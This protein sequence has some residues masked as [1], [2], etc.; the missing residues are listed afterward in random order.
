MANVGNE[1]LDR[2]HGDGF[3]ELH[4]IRDQ[5]DFFQRGF[6][7]SRFTV[8][9]LF[10]PDIRERQQQQHEGHAQHDKVFRNPSHFSLYLCGRGNRNGSPLEIL[11][12]L[13][14]HGA[15]FALSEAVREVGT[16]N[17]KMVANQDIDIQAQHILQRVFGVFGGTLVFHQ[18]AQEFAETDF[19]EIAENINRVGFGVGLFFNVPFIDDG[20]HTQFGL[21]NLLQIRFGNMPR[22][23]QVFRL[24]WLVRAFDNYAAIVFIAEIF[25]PFPFEGGVAIGN[26]QRDFSQRFGKRLV[27]IH[28]LANMIYHHMQRTTQG[29]IFGLGRTATDPHAFTRHIEKHIGQRGSMQL[30]TINLAHIA[31]APAVF[32][33]VSQTRFEAAPF[34]FHSLLKEFGSQRV[35][36]FHPFPNHD[37]SLDQFVPRTQHQILVVESH[38]WIFQKGAAVCGCVIHRNHE[39][40]RASLDQH[41]PNQLF[42]QIQTLAHRKLP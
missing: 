15:G 13:A 19:R 6:T 32:Q 7:Q 20:G 24:D 33:T 37:H 41:L 38:T 34:F 42:H 36:A 2:H 17:H 28:R 40:A 14:A 23:A 26:G 35:I 16:S 12:F 25:V 27:A 39:F 11:L 5:Q 31:N 4:C 1:T 10:A 3:T 29:N 9:E 21:N 18:C 30:G 22:M 8:V